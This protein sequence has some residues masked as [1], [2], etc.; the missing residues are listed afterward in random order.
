MLISDWTSKSSPSRGV[1]ADHITSAADGMP[2]IQ[3]DYQQ[4]LLFSHIGESIIRFQRR[5]VELSQLASFSLVYCLYYLQPS[6][7][8]ML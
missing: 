5:L 1:G 4:T 3:K 6:L 7:V 8:H 2:D